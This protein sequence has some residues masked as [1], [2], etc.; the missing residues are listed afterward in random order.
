MS[1]YYVLALHERFLNALIEGRKKFEI[2]TRIPSDIRKGDWL[3]LVQ[4]GTH[5]KIQS[6]ARIKRIYANN[7]AILWAEHQQ[8]LGITL[9]EYQDYTKGREQI[10]LLEFDQ[11]TDARSSRD[12]IKKLG[13]K[14][15]PQWFQRID[16]QQII[17]NH[18]IKS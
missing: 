1:N 4:T 17:Q 7:P 3:F 15:T 13:L 9:E 14:R 16:M 2:R 6:A 5:G 11:I 12:T 18:V 8:E 10:Y